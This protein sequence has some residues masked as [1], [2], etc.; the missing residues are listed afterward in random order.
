ME[1][2]LTQ[3]ANSLTRQ[4]SAEGLLISD[5]TFDCLNFKGS[6]VFTG[7]GTRGVVIKNAHDI[8]IT[9][10]DCVIDNA[11]TGVMIKL[12]GR[13]NNVKLNGSG[14]TRL[15]GKAGN[16][17]SQVIYVVGTWSNVEICG[18]DIDQRR[19][20]STGSSTTT[21]ACVQT[22]GVFQAGHNLGTFKL[23]D[24][25]LRNCGDE[26]S[27]NNYN[28]G[29]TGAAKGELIIISNVKVLNCGRDPFQTQGF[30]DVIIEYCYAEN[31]GIEGDKNHCSGMSLNGGHERITVRDSAFVNMAQL[32]Y[33]GTEGTKVEAIFERVKYIQGKHMGAISNQC[34]YLKSPGNYHFEDCDFTADTK[35][36]ILTADGSTITYRN[37]R[38]NTPDKIARLFNGGT[39]KELPYVKTYPLTIEVTETTISGITTKKY[40]LDGVEVVLKSLV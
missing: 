29:T 35:E 30:K 20:N 19:D 4:K 22:A 31:A 11:G 32:V 18:F 14:T 1:I 23:F 36:A 21:G 28:T 17:Q 16:A 7:K 26:G 39:V 40:F 37:C 33:C 34:A 15:F 38:F 13:T 9:F 25:T 6:L 24:M 12:D 3:H 27:Y 5:H 10:K 8:E 2:N